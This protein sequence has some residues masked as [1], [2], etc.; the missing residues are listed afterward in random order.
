MRVPVQTGQ[1]PPT[2]RCLTLWGA[3][4]CLCDATGH[5]H[6]VLTFTSSL[7]GDL[8]ESIMKRDAGLKVCGASLARLRCS[9]LLHPCLPC[10]SPPHGRMCCTKH[11]RHCRSRCWTRPC[12]CRTRATSFP[13]TAACWTGLTATSSQEPSAT[14]TS[15]HCCRA[16]AWHER[17]RSV[18]GCACAA[19][20][21]GSAAAAACNWGASARRR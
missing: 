20:T 9:L 7:F 5:H 14:F 13:G 17:A 18:S 2:P 15:Q 19:V 1:A 12:C 11:A 6:Q 10:P 21:L 16:S 3:R 8:I 4:A